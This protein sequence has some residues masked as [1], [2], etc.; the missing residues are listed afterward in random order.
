MDLD[1]YWMGGGHRLCAALFFGLS[2]SRRRVN[3]GICRRRPRGLFCRFLGRL[4]GWRHWSIRRRHWSIRRRHRRIR[5]RYR[6]I[7]GR[8]RLR[9]LCRRLWRAGGRYRRRRHKQRPKRRARRL[10]VGS[11][12]QDRLQRC[13]QHQSSDILAKRVSDMFDSQRTQNLAPQ[14]D[15]DP[16]TG[17]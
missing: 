10:S 3:R 4:L 8:R 14:G 7:C 6:R 5:R 11:P 15:D 9:R 2:R 1:C 13:S 17:A 16:L 12:D